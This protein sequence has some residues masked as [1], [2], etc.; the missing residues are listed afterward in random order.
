MNTWLT[1]GTLTSPLL[2]MRSLGQFPDPWP[3]LTRLGVAAEGLVEDSRS[4][5]GLL[6]R[7][8]G[9]VL[10][11]RNAKPLLPLSTER[12][13]LSLQHTHHRPPL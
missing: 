7:V 11:T 4:V 5:N 3:L 6:L 2:C 12:K 13:A 8:I 1:S 9:L 10:L